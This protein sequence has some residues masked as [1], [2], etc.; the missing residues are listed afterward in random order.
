MTVYQIAEKLNF[1][2]LVGNE[3]AKETDVAGIY[4]CDLLSVVM[5]SCPANFAW[6]TVMGNINSVAVSVLADAACIILAENSN[7]DENAY[8]KAVDTDVI[9]LKSNNKIFETALSIH[10]LGV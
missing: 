6:I 9:V 2:I 3:Q 8:K 10:D 4:C 1:E 5:G 7:L